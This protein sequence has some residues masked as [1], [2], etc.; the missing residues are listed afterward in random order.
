M[1]GGGDEIFLEGFAI[2]WS[3]YTVIPFNAAIDKI[4]LL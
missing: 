3:R 2:V 1:S 4:L